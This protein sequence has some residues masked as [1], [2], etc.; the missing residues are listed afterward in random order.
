MVSKAFMAQL[1]AIGK[2]GENVAVMFTENENYEDSINQAVKYLVNEKKIPGIFVTVNK[3]GKTRI[4]ALKK[5]GVNTDMIIMINVGNTS[6]NTGCVNI[7]S[8]KHLTDLAVGI[9]HAIEAIPHKDRFLFFDSLSTYLVYN[10]PQSVMRFGQFLAGKMRAYDMKGV[11]MSFKKKDQP[12]L[13]N[14]LISIG[15]IV[16]DATEKEVKK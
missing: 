2:N 13:E 1:G 11:I 10:S 14:F 16:I 12:D 6:T 15:D 3:P 7:P 8:A 4:D 5:I 9:S